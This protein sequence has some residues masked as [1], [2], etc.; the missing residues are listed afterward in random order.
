MAVKAQANQPG[1]IV[2]Q[3]PV[4]I[5]GQGDAPSSLRNCPVVD[6]ENR[7]FATVG[8]TLV[9]LKEE[10]GEV[11][12]LWEYP[13]GGRAPGSP[14]LGGDG[15]LRVH[16]SDGKLHCVSNTGE[17]VWAPVDV[18]EPLGWASPVVDDEEHNT[19]VSSYTGGLIKIDAGG[20][21]KKRPYFYSR[22]KFDSTGLIHQNVLYV[23]AED[24]FVY[25]VELQGSRGSN[26]WDPLAD[27]GKTGW[28]V[29]SAPALTPDSS[30]IV[31]GRD[32]YLYAFD[33]QGKQLWKIHLRGQMLA[34]PVVDAKG[35]IYV[36]VTLLKSGQPARGKLVCIN[37]S[38]HRVR[39]EY[40]AEGAVESTPVIGDDETVYFGDN[41]GKV[42]AVGFDGQSRWVQ[43]VGSPV[44]S[45]GTIPAKNR[46]LFGLDKGTLVALV[47][48]SQGL[49]G[50]GWPK[51]MGSLEQSGCGM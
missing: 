43:D 2:W 31:A 9:A 36:G 11:K 32:E 16:T 10:Q 40:K 8:R 3:Y 23:G 12:E 34:S 6:G 29:N 33:L 46:L 13:L 26:R 14:S 17:Q 15:R 47:C 28:F 44:R 18:G 19:W 4:F 27:E 38:S 20:M 24:G 51:Y 39:W 5:P 37:G 1:N 7:I 21:R 50:Q 48:S 30:I 45:A 35:D 42:H 41:E 25:A 22:Q 49:A